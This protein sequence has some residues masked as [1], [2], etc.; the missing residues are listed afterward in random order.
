MK[1]DVV[2]AKSGT[3]QQPGPADIHSLKVNVPAGTRPNKNLITLSCT[4]RSSLLLSPASYDFFQSNR[5]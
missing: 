3:P 2:A 4:S 5:T 1:V